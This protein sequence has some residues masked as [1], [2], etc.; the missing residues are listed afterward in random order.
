MK[1]LSFFFLL[2]PLWWLG[3]FSARAQQ[4]VK[5]IGEDFSTGAVTFTVDM[6]A[7]T[8]TWVFVE[9]TNPPTH[10]PA[11]MS[12]ATFTDVQFDPQDAGTWTPG[13]T[14][15]AGDRG[16]FLTKSATVTA[17]LDVAPGMFSWCA[18]AISAPPRAKVKAEGGYS[19]HGT[20]P[21]TINGDLLIDSDDFSPGTCITSFTDFTYNPDGFFPDPPEVIAT[22]PTP[23]CADAVTFT[24]TASGGITDVMSYTWSIAG[25]ETTTTSDNPYLT[26]LATT[27][28]ADTYTYTV[29]V[30]NANGCTSTVSNMGTV[31]V[32][33]VP[34]VEDVSSETV[35]SGMSATLSA[36]VTDVTP[37]AIY[38]WY[39][40]DYSAETTTTSTYTTPALTAT[41]TTYLTYRVQI[42][43][44]TGCTSTVSDAGTITV[45]P[46]PVPA[47]V[48]PPTK[49]C[50]NSEVIFTASDAG[51]ASSSYC[52]TYQCSKCLRNP[53]LTGEEVPPAVD[54]LWDS[55][56]EF[57]T[58]N[59][60][61]VIMPDSGSMTIW[62]QAMNQYGCT[63]AATTAFTIYDAVNAGSIS[64]DGETICHGATVTAITGMDAFCGDGA[65]SYQWRE[66]ANT[67][68]TDATYDPSSYNSTP[69][70][71]T[72]T[73]WAKDGTSSTW[74][75]SAGQWVLTVREAFSAGS[76]ITASTTTGQGTPSSVTVTSLVQA[77]GGDG[78]II[79]QWQRSDGNSATTLSGVN[80]TYALDM[81]E[82][83][84]STAGTYY[85]TRYAMDGACNTTFTASSGQYMLT[86]IPPPP[87]SGTVTWT[88][89][90][91]T[92]SGALSHSVSGCTSTSTLSG[93]N[94]PPA[95][96]KN[97]N[98][99]TFGYY[100]NWTCVNAT[101]GDLCP[102]P[103]R[104]PSQEDFNAL[105]QSTSSSILNS[106]WG[107][108]GYARSNQVRDIG[109][110]DNY[111]SS[112]ES[113]DTRA[114][115]TNL[116]SITSLE[117]DYGLQVRCVR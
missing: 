75:Q 17:T 33:A 50:G 89:G 103:W 3:G 43:N 81:D 104:V 98:S 11:N 60:Y 71:Y 86:V 28:D 61:S 12:R 73:R 22:A 77:S 37:S 101:A 9:Y 15:T 82:E 55:E 88:Y 113:S 72:F 92:W 27:G 102:S 7:T 59:T 21:F 62:V 95:Q 108:A 38:T 56:C 47:F 13:S 79:Y 76:I 24:A 40:G 110:W 35:C 31:T 57:G 112:K 41:A 45:N 4:S 68:T 23:V 19:L 97:N 36:T 93:D 29:F 83:N 107:K 2:L 32:Y 5:L 34:V 25:A 30:T 39:V 70:T 99:A 84:Y 91:Q 63:S 46:L 74:T 85:F 69:G 49:A 44:L 1:K 52:F 111:W 14:E 117:K 96:Y 105:L 58:A 80:D 90:T 10:D 26:T 109:I 65:I 53:F 8:R 100:Y 66:G 94:P 106:A 54:C 20:R 78:N 18:Y 42:T 16:F 48:S 64:S 67:L 114:I 51:G 6:G 115:Y 116:S 87:Y